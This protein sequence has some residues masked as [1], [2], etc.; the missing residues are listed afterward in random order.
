MIYGLCAHNTGRIF[1]VTESYA[2]LVL[3]F[4]SMASAHRM[5]QSVYINGSRVQIIPP[6]LFFVNC[7]RAFS[8][9]CV[10]KFVYSPTF[11]TIHSLLQLC[12]M[13]PWVSGYSNKV[14]LDTGIGKL[15]FHY[16]NP[17]LA[18]SFLR[19]FTMVSLERNGTS[20]EQCSSKLLET[21]HHYRAMQQ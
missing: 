14:K 3:Q 6:S 13:S 4:Y 15:S 20:T 16:I 21:Y 8:R 7:G 18:C 1:L 17:T 10:K 11:I 12:F 19:N 9:R 5:P 2:S